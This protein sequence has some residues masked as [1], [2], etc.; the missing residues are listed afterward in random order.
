M[1][2]VVSL[3]LRPLGRC[4]AIVREAT[5]EQMA[6]RYVTTARSKGL[7]GSKAVNRHVVRNVVPVTAT[8]FAYDFVLIFTG[9]AAYVETVFEWPGVGKLAVDAVLHHDVNLIAACV[10]VAG[11]VVAVVN[12]LVDLTHAIIDRR[13]EL[14]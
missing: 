7:T 4:A 10:F 11:V 8:V 5:R 14:S 6:E 13:V 12:I 1:L 2:P 9:Y 3:A